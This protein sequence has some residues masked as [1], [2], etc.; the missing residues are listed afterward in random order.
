MIVPAQQD[1]TLLADLAAAQD[2]ADTLHVWWLGQSGFLV[3]WNGQ[4][5][6]FDPYL[7]DSLTMKYA[8]TDKPHVRLTERCI[9]PAKL[10]GITRVTASHVHTDHLDAETLLP[11]AAGSPGFRLYHPVPILA[12]V[13]KRTAGAPIALYG[14]SETSPSLEGDW[15]IHATTAKHNEV[16]RDDQGNSAYIGFLVRCGPFRLFH[17]GDTLWHD[18]LV[19]QCQAFGPVDVAFLPING[20]KPE[21]RVAGNLDGPEAAV[22]AKA[23]GAKVVIPCHYEMFEFNTASPETFV[24][25]C[26]EIGQPFQVMRCGERLDLKR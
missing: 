15:E 22:L 7:S 19:K 13:K 23:I 12:E 25:A 24:A 21:R 14:L 5:M 6:L 9:D 11:L 3:Q 20:N 26:Q 10:S 1:D 17:S 18:D 4:R 8:T 16:V 2:G